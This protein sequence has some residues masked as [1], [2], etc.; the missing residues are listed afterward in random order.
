MEIDPPPADASV[1]GD[2]GSVANAEGSTPG[3]ANPGASKG[4][5][6]KESVSEE[7]GPDSTEKAAE[8][9]TEAQGQAS[10]GKAR[11]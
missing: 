4:K 3:D 2:V 11:I 1:A 8:P 6:Q 10:V 5:E 7:R 9:T